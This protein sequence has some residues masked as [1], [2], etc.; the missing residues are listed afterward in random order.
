MT[1]YGIDIIDR[2]IED[3]F[4]TKEEAIEF[5][6]DYYNAEVLPHITDRKGYDGKIWLAAE[7]VHEDVHNLTVNGY[8]DDILFIEPIELHGLYEN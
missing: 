8:I 6:L 7:Q 2:G 5:A 3:A 1:I 4:K